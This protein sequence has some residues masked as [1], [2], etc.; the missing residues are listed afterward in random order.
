M[1]NDFYLLLKTLFVLEFFCSAEERLD[2]K[3]MVNFNFMTSQTR[4]QIITIQISFI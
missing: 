3:A 1:K 4:Q 2:K